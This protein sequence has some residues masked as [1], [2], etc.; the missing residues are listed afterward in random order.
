[1]AGIVKK[2]LD[3][4]NN[5]EEYE[6]DEEELEEEGN[7][8][9]RN[10]RK[11]RHSER[12][13]VININ[14]GKTKISCFKPDAYDG[15]IAEIANSLL[16]RHI[17]AVDLEIENTSPDIACRII[18]FLRGTVHAVQGNFVKVSRNTYVLTPNT[19]EIDGADLIN[20]LVSHDIYI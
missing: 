7:I 15:Q 16:N 8:T 9:D 11:L 4:W 10:R 13:K 14:G 20:Q 6:D 1:M 19:V 3:M 17:V 5:E 18:D 12:S 2:F